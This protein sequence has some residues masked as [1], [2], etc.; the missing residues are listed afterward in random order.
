M[1][2]FSGDKEIIVGITG[3][4]G[5]R[6]M[7][8]EHSGEMLVLMEEEPSRPRPGP[9]FSDEYLSKQEEEMPMEDD[10]SEQGNRFQEVVKAAAEL[11]GLADRLE[12]MVSVSDLPKMAAG[13]M[14]YGPSV[15]G[16][17][18]PEM[19][20]PMKRGSRK[21]RKMPDTDLASLQNLK[22]GAMKLMGSSRMSPDDAPGDMISPQ[23][24]RLRE[25][26]V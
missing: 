3:E 10:M 14:A 18:G 16:E 20:V 5:R 11:R 24:K 7:M 15:V 1:H 17:D 19:V 8:P 4:P 25:G 12:S 23:E 22:K 2:P 21:M 13:G 6:E 26:L 9:R